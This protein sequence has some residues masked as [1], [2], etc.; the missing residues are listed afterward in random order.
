MVG[1]GRN[2]DRHLCGMQ[3]RGAYKKNHGLGVRGNA[4]ARVSKSILSNSTGDLLDPWSTPSLDNKPEPCVGVCK[5]LAF[6]YI[7]FDAASQRRGD[8]EYINYRCQRGAGRTPSQ[9]R[10]RRPRASWAVTFGGW[11]RQWNRDWVA[12]V[13]FSDTHWDLLKKNTKQWTIFRAFLIWEKG[14]NSQQL[15]TEVWGGESDSHGDTERSL[16]IAL[17]NSRARIP[18]SKC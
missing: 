1:W 5:R 7:S 4:L 2:V 10:S 3:I 12:S 9:T 15:A 6:V 11:V 13:T 18:K 16:G 8:A 14:G 17:G